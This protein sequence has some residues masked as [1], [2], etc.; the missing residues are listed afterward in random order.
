MVVGEVA[1]EV[2]VLVIGGGIGGYSAA[3]RASQLGRKVT[4]VER[5]NLGGV[6][7]HNG[8]IPSKALISASQR[9]QS[10]LQASELGLEFEEVRVNFSKV[11]DW[12]RSVIKK[13]TDGVNKLL[14]G[15]KVEILKG[16]A[17]FI[18]ENEVRVING[19]ESNR[20]HFNY[21]VIATG[22]SPVE[23]PGI[24]FGS[25]VLSST[26]ALSLSRVPDRLV[27]IGGGYIG[28]ELSQAY[29]KFGTKVTILES[30][31]SILPQFE[32][33]A[34]AQVNRNLKG[35]GVT[36]YTNTKVL[37]AVESE[38]EVN[39]FFEINGESLQV[40]ADYLLVTV[41]RRPN[42]D[43]IGL[44][45]LDINVDSKGYLEVN[46]RCQTKFPNIF[47]IGD[48]I[49]GP[50]LAHKASYEGKVAA[51]VI[52][53]MATQVDYQAI[54]IVVFSDPEIAA[55]GLSEQEAKDRDFDIDV[56]TYSYGANGRAYTMEAAEGFIKI[57]VEKGSGLI[58]GALIV[59]KNASDLIA[60][61]VFAIETCS[62]VE[63]II[64]TVHAHPTLSE[65]V[66]EAAE[67]VYNRK[68]FSDHQSINFL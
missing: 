46:D 51:E 42:T 12:K 44:D 47:A 49:S 60:Q 30:H 6:C 19:Y 54:P 24:P 62:T 35:N 32:K 7:L 57:V 33:R 67:A 64:S 15:N 50:A 45:L 55:A 21:C 38:N 34:V 11:Q 63:D 36:I 8:C 18:N 61:L 10:I 31:E 27:V 2:D 9:Y 25:R 16:E 14:K 65:M 29:A 1:N 68:I 26:E 43:E 5:E 58:L 28:I 59:G 22:S 52:C 3:I 56:G 20:I 13:L 48:V 37:E 39:V 4:I 23:L 41:G 53:G 17:F 40:S 66:M